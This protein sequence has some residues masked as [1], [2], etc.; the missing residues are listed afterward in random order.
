MKLLPLSLT[1]NL[2]WVRLLPEN[3]QNRFN[4]FQFLEHAAKFS[5]KIFISPCNFF[6]PLLEPATEEEKI[7]SSDDSF[8]GSSFSLRFDQFRKGKNRSVR[9]CSEMKS[10]SCGAESK[11]PNQLGHFQA[12]SICPGSD[13]HRAPFS[14][15]FRKLNASSKRFLKPGSSQLTRCLNRKSK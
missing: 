6:S 7:F 5:S 11:N 14:Q 4:G 12:P 1:P 2:S 9:F 10:I 3:L 8:F 15:T 13:S